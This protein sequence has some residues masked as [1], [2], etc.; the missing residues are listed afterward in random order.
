VPPLHVATPGSA[1]QV[2]AGY[3]QQ[4]RE[5]VEVAPR[6]IAY[7][8]VPAERD[9]GAL[10]A[11]AHGAGKVRRRRGAAAA[12]EDELLQ[13]WKLGIPAFEFGLERQTWLP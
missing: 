2:S 7:R 12:G 13:R 5:P 4:V 11:P 6:E 9:Q 10:G 1:V 8:L 3:E